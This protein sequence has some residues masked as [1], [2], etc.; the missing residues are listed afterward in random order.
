MRFFVL[1][2]LAVLGKGGAKSK[3]KTDFKSF[4]CMTMNLNLKFSMCKYFLNFIFEIWGYSFYDFLGFLFN[5][6]VY[7]D[8]EELT[9]PLLS[10]LFIRIQLFY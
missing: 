2:P 3:G 9:I 6:R 5:P 4:S 8:F 1:L 7:I 10:S